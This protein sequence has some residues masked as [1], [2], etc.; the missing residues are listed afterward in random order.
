MKEVVEVVTRDGVPLMA[1]WF[2]TE[3]PHEK[4]V[5]INSATGVKQHYYADFASWLTTQGFNVYTFD[6]RGIGGSRGENISDNLFDMNDWSTDVDAMISHITRIHPLSQ[7]VILGHSVGGQL[8]GMSRLTRQADALVMIGSQTPYWKNYA[9]AW[10]KTK[11]W[12]FWNVT[13]PLGTR[14]FGYFPA[15]K[16]GL[17]ED[18]PAEVARQWARWA[19]SENYI[20]DELPE[21]RVNFVAL[22]QPTLMLSFADDHLAPHAA[23]LDLKRFYRNLKIDHWHVHPDDVMQRSVGHF[24]FFKKRMETVLW[25]ETVSWIHKVLLPGNKRAA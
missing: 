22:N 11:L 2:I 8:I 21:E 4:V 12:F 15:S 6:Y 23:V 19:K 16:L 13:V 3:S 20:F 5:L 1:T 10:M 9:G 7:V 25:R 24:G 18:L 14:L 17:F